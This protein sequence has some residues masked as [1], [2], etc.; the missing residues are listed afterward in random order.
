MTDTFLTGQVDAPNAVGTEE[1]SVLAICGERPD[2]DALPA[3]GP[4][5]DAMPALEA[6]VVLGGRDDAHDLVLVI[7]DLRQ[8]V[9]HRACAR[10]VTAR[11]HVLIEGFVRP[12]E[13]VDGAP[14]IERALHLGEGTKSSE[15]EDFGL[16]GAVEALIL[17]AALRVVRSAVQDGDAELEQPH[18]QS[19]PTCSGPI[20]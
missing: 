8:T 10:P 5:H 13:I 3:K 7:L 19:R 15:C 4:R 11:R 2:R 6:D 9:R 16:Q 12:L 18:A 1:D 20:P 14:D 17:A